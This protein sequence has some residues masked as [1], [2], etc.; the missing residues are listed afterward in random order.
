V[1]SVCCYYYYYYYYY[2]FPITDICVWNPSASN[3][4]PVWNREYFLFPSRSIGVFYLLAERF[5]FPLNLMSLAVYRHL[6]YHLLAV[7]LFRELPRITP[8]LVIV[9]GRSIVFSLACQNRI[10][11]FFPIHNS[12]M[13]NWNPDSFRAD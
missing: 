10:Y 8:A 2:F 6:T 13:N 12:D 7:F 1:L 4:Q 9:S 3:F 11:I 5:F